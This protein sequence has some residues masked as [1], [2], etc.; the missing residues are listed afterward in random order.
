M[1]EWLELAGKL[2][3]EGLEWYAGFLEM[4]DER[5]WSKFCSMSEDHRKVIPMGEILIFCWLEP[6]DIRRAV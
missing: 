5:N 6:P 1:A 4:S 2:D 3:I